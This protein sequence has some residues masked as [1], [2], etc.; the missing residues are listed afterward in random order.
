MKNWVLFFLTYIL[1][2]PTFGQTANPQV[3]EKDIYQTST[4]WTELKITAFVKEPV[5]MIVFDESDPKFG[6]EN[7]A[8]SQGRAHSIARKKAKERLKIRL[9][10][11]LES[12]LF[13]SDF[14]VY[15]Y[16]QTRQNVRLS[17]NH[18]LAKDPETYDFLFQKNHLEAKAEISIRGKEGVLSHIPIEF[19]TEEMPIFTEEL[20]AV[21]FSGL[22]VDARHLKLN[23]ALL[24]KIQTDRGLDI[25]SPIYTKEAYAIEKGYIHYSKDTKERFVERI[26]GKNPY[27]VLG[28]GVSGK[29]QTDII[30]PTDEVVKLLSHPDSRKNITRCRVL[31]LV[32]D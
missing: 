2:F 5:P 28:L 29:N 30:L 8:T 27:F 20:P 25:Y 15:E 21:A 22:I 6:K 10:Q 26:V 11:R 9:S 31:I 4:N 7:T 19:G 24:P 14:T 17:L 13:N 16:T 1:S 32:S 12:L 23:K 18:F 3:L